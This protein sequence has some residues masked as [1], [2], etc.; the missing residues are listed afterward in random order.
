MNERTKKIGVFDS[1]FGGLN[2]LKYIVEALPEYDYVYLGDTARVPYGNRS[3]EIVYEFTVQALEFLFKHDCDLVILA[4][5]TASSDALKRIQ[6][7]YLPKF[8]P[9]KKVLGVLIPA[10]ESAAELTKNK[11]V[12]VMATRGTVES[13]TF[14][15]EILK[16]D[17]S[18]SVFQVACPL[19]VPV[20]EAGEEEN[21]E[22]LSILLSKYLKEL[23]NAEID[24]LILGCTHYGI[25]K[26]A[27]QK[28]MGESVAIID[29]GP[30][31]GA[32]L[33]EY[34]QKHTEIELRLAKNSS[35]KIF[36]TD[37]TLGFKVLGSKF[38]GEP[39]EVEFTVI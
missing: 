38:F 3:F 35:K 26:S 37:L 2:I 21:V 17:E 39:I 20:I 7:E 4:C 8:Y 10:A 15:R 24:T 13:G 29:E 28:Y 22:L 1:G 16:Q 14:V 25:I 30:I 33:K 19:L 5:N 9:D 34:L 27:I 6:T 31:V 36:T 12:G 18:I 11:K 32:K 23:K